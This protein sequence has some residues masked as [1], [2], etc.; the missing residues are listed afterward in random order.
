M[1]AQIK[2]LP[3]VVYQTINF[4]SDLDTQKMVSHVD[5]LSRGTLRAIY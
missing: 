3:E 4:Y 5:I 2:V 1:P